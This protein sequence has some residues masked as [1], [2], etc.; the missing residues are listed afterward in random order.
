MGKW[1]NALPGDVIF[2]AW[3]VQEPCVGMESI[4]DVYIGSEVSQGP[5]VDC[6]ATGT[7]VGG[8][9]LSRCVTHDRLR[10]KWESAKSFRFGDSRV[11]KSEYSVAAALPTPSIRRGVQTTVLFWIRTDVIP[12][13]TVPLLISRQSL[14]KLKGELI[15]QPTYYLLQTTQF[16]FGR[17]IMGILFGHVW[18]LTHVT[19]R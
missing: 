5:V 19:H 1:R 12:R 16:S 13:S 4:K 9:W 17:L 11:F 6:G 3:E 7:V 18:L 8:N 15:S 14:G 10:K 2:V